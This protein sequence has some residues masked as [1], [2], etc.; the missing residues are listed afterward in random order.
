MKHWGGHINEVSFP[1]SFTVSVASIKGV[2]GNRLGGW[3]AG[4]AVEY[5]QGKL[6]V[7]TIQ[8]GGGQ[9]TVLWSDDS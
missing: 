5:I 4:V 3:C 9:S 2:P 7:C 8:M 1:V 6:W